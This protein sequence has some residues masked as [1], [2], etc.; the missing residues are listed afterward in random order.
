[1]PCRPLTLTHSWSVE[2]IDFLSS[3]FSSFNISCIFV[4][5]ASLSLSSFLSLT[6]DSC[7]CSLSSMASLSRKIEAI[8]SSILLR[9]RAHFSSLHVLFI[10]AAA[11]ILLPST[12][13]VLPSISPSFMHM[14][15]H[16]F[17]MFLSATLLFFLNLA[18]VLW[19]GLRPPISQINDMLWYTARSNFR[20]LLIPYEYP[21][22]NNFII[23]FGSYSGLPTWSSS[24]S[25]RSS[26][27]SSA[28]TIPS[29]ARTGSSFKT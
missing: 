8:C 28:S 19:S 26:L 16:C 2:F 15:A 29:Y 3:L 22:V 25:I 18:I 10:D 6:S 20:E 23:A 4:L 21:Y 11:L 27:K 9:Y 12:N 7:S 17:N 13:N 1:M 24:H 5:S 14:R